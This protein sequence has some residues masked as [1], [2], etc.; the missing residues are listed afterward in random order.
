ME[1]RKP[2]RGGCLVQRRLFEVVVGQE[3]DGASH[4]AIVAA[5]FGVFEDHVRVH[6]LKMA[7][8][9]APFDP[10]LAQIRRLREPAGAPT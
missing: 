5:S 6:G 7:K 8:D 10:F 2:C 1:G 9:T 3:A 4:L